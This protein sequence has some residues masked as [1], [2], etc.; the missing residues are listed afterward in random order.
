[1]PSGS[2]EMLSQFLPQAYGLTEAVCRTEAPQFRGASVGIAGSGLNAGL[3]QVISQQTSDGQAGERQRPVLTENNAMSPTR[4]SGDR[5]IGNSS[6]ARSTGKDNLKLNPEI[7]ANVQAAALGEGGLQSTA[8]TL[9]PTASSAGLLLGSA[10]ASSQLS[11]AITKTDNHGLSSMMN[12][13]PAADENVHHERITAAKIAVTKAAAT[14][15]AATKIAA[16]K[17]AASEIAATEDTPSAARPSSLSAD[18]TSTSSS[19]SV[20]RSVPASPQPRSQAASP[21]LHDGLPAAAGTP[22]VHAHT[23]AHDERSKKL[24]SAAQTK[25]DLEGGEANSHTQREKTRRLSLK[26]GAKMTHGYLS[27]VASS[28]SGTDIFAN[29]QTAAL[30]EA[31]SAEQLLQRHRHK[32]S[33]GRALA[34]ATSANLGVKGTRVAAAIL[35]AQVCAAWQAVAGAFVQTMSTRTS[36]GSNDRD[37]VAL[38]VSRAV[39]LAA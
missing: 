18:L 13:Q 28:A 19:T 1:M 33:P 22:S 30:Q 6:G 38:S 10:N 36:C 7:S 23:T 2:D 14:K 16:T 31:A 34:A 32:R 11:A 27:A 26:S 35:V 24:A 39:M 12:K 9:L 15:T 8:R 37:H 29:R 25:V 21:D 17:N 3:S 20:L 5:H 4:T